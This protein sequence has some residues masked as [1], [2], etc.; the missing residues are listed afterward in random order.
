MIL[1]NEG[2]EY[3][4]LNSGRVCGYAILYKQFGGGNEINRT[5]LN[6]KKKKQTNKKKI[7]V[8]VSLKSVRQ[9]DYAA[10]L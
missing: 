1:N 6:T 10:P 2:C 4:P 3:C 5:V 8:P 9:W 7:R